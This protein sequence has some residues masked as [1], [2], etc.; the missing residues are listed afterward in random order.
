MLSKVGAQQ[1]Q[2]QAGYYAHAEDPRY[3]RSYVGARTI[4]GFATFAVV[5]TPCCASSIS[6]F[7]TAGTTSTSLAVLRPLVV[8][9]L[10]LRVLAVPKYPQY[11]QYTSSMKYTST[12][13]APCRQFLVPLFGTKHSQIVPRVGVGANYFRWGQ[14]EYFR[15]LQYFDLCSARDRCREYSL[16][17]MYCGYCLYSQVFRVSV[18]RVRTFA[19]ALGVRY[20][21]IILSLLSVFGPSQHSQYFSRQYSNTLSTGT[22]ISSRAFI[23]EAFLCYPEHKENFILAGCIMLYALYLT[24]P[25]TKYYSATST[26]R[27][28]FALTFTPHT[29]N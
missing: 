17:V 15:A 16:E 1:Q 12:V 27:N 28:F 7:C 21:S 2:Q 4:S 3:M 26:S 6:G 9:V 18:L 29:L 10:L 14:L 11:A 8:F 19:C 5:D 23:C 20:C 24:Q 22:T 25:A 13:C